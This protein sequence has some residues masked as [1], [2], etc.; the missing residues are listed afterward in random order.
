[1]SNRGVLY[2][3]WGP[4]RQ[5]VL[6]RSIASLKRVHP[7]LPY[8]IERLPEG[9]T[10]LDKAVMA[11][12]SPFES[13]L[14][15][16]VDTV[17]LDRLDFGFQ[18]AERVGLAC[19]ICECPWARRYGGLKD[20]GDL[21]EYNTGVLFFTPKSRPVFDAWKAHRT[22]D[23]SI[24][25]FPLGSDQL[26][27]MASND[28]GPFAAAIDST[29]FVPFI[30]P[31]NYNFRPAWHRSFFGPL[32]IWHD[33]REPPAGIDQHNAAQSTPDSVIAYAQMT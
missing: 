20:R 19:S 31:L 27:V 12:R 16:D 14:F 32:K 29:G 7:E 18:Q 1:M 9:A 30:L 3:I 8:H 5:P 17:V 13:T 24:R 21:L 2:M 11:D 10:L 23:S 22:M 28:Q 15:L 6:D 4:E 26:H 33:Y 25:F